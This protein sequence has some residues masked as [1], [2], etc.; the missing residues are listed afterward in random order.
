MGFPMA[1]G[2]ERDRTEGR[3]GGRGGALKQGSDHHYRGAIVLQL[4]R[5]FLMRAPQGG[6]QVG[7][8]TG[9]WVGWG[10]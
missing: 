4:S 6:G 1:Q 2:G 10:D 5:P 7:T 9:R 3:G 8:E